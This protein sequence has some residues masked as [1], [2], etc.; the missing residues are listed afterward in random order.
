MYM[1]IL[2]IEKIVEDADIVRM[3]QNIRTADLIL[4][5]PCIYICACMYTVKITRNAISVL[6]I[7]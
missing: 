5:F 1:S 2:Y 4:P 3:N 7:H 6:C